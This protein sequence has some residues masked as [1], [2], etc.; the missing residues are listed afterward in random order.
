ME[1]KELKDSFILFANSI[2]AD[3]KNAICIDDKNINSI[4]KKLIHPYITY[5]FSNNA[6]IQAKNEKYNGNNT[7]YE[8]WINNKFSSLIELSIPG[9]HNILNSLG[10]I[11]IA[12]E[13][14][15]N[16]NIIKKC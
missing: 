5:G 6:N 8:L 11:A 9:N 7:I 10:A 2:S 1:I 3:K 4:Q 14:G 13:M 15:V 16:I 12:I